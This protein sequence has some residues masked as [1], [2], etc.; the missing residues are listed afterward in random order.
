MALAACGSGGGLEGVGTDL[1]DPATTEILVEVDYQPGAEPYVGT[2]M[3]GTPFW[4]L[5]RANIERLFP[6]RSIDVPVDLN[7]MEMLDDVS[8]DS[9]SGEDLLAIAASHDDNPDNDNTA[10][11]YLVFVDGLFFSEGE[12]QPTVLGVSLGDSRVIG[13]FK[14]VIRSTEGPVMATSRF[15]EQSTV[16]HEL[17]HA[18][19]LVNNGIP[20]TSEHHDSAHG[21]HCTNQD[22]VMYFAN[23]G[24]ADL[25]DFVRDFVATG[26]LVLFADD[27][28]ADADAA[29]Q[30]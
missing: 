12:E 15:V 22:C 27:C 8:G 30:Q 1:L 26:D 9:F 10:T 19:G 23:E 2:T 29:D 18:V 3:N 28:L 24:A 7:E 20:L 6:G 4:E 21:A 13:M 25:A 17:G 16:V 14:P 5:T 11:F